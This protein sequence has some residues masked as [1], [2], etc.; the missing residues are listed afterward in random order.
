[1]R[2]RSGRAAE[3][4]R[5]APGAQWQRGEPH[6]QAIPADRQHRPAAADGT[7]AIGGRFDTSPDMATQLFCLTCTVPG[8]VPPGMGIT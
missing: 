4:R 5:R 6:L 7:T 1:M 3:G 8:S 2:R